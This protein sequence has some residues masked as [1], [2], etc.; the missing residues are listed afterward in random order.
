[1]RRAAALVVALA[2]GGCG[3]GESADAPEPRREV[4]LTIVVEPRGPSGP[5]LTATLTCDPASGSHPDPQA[6]CAVLARHE[7]AL[8]PVPPDVAC[9][10]IYGGPQ[11]AEV[12][13]TAAGG[14]VHA[15]L[16]RTNGCEIDRWERLAPLLALS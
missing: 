16:N 2:L 12:E 15:E 14:E 7:E 4:N 9:T 3:G 8:E 1:M 6:A 11:R 5:E 10:E 13:G